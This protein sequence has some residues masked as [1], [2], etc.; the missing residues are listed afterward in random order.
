M[1]RREF[2]E[3]VVAIVERDGALDAKSDAERRIFVASGFVLRNRL[4]LA[5]DF[6]WRG[7]TP[8]E[9]VKFLSDLDEARRKKLAR[10]ASELIE[11]AMGSVH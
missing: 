1:K 5:D 6:P 4:G 7:P 9:L 10:I 8:A 11:E 3:A 2:D